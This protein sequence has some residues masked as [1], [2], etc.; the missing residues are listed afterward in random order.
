MISTEQELEEM[1]DRHETV[2]LDFWAKWCAP[3]RGFG[4]VFEA[5]AKLNADMA[6]CRVDTEESEELKHAFEVN[7]IPTLAVIR[8]RVLV[9]SQSGY[10]DKAALT[11]L[12]E[13][14]RSLDMDAV[15]KQAESEAAN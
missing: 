9:A 7:S 11:D 13:Q 1:I 3:C 5:V 2:V 15:R 10:M 8:D 6:F 14:V 4:P 12:I